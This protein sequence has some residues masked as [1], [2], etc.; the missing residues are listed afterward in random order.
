ML[1]EVWNS[2]TLTE[3]QY[4]ESWSTWRTFKRTVPPWRYFGVKEITRD[5]ILLIQQFER[6]YLQRRAKKRD[7]EY[8]KDKQQ[9]QQGSSGYR[10]NFV[11]RNSRVQSVL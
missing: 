3:K 9:G 5:H 10:P 6:M 1:Y 4:Y 7:M 11:G 2:M 8:N